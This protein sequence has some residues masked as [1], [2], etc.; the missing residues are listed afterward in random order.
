MGESCWEWLGKGGANGYGMF[1]IR[2]A[3]RQYK[4]LLAH[5]F[6]WELHFGEIP[7][8]LF[9]LHH[10]D[11]RKCVNP[12]H[13][14][15]GTQ[16]DNIADMWAK[17]RGVHGEQRRQSKLKEVQVKEIRE[18]YRAGENISAVARG[19]GVTRQAV[20]AAAIGKN[21]KRLEER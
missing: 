1:G 7:A 5:R 18:R 3:R 17:G 6:S 12:A 21:W 19:Y 13:L 20:H 9:V 11:N 14:F 4:N 8:N 10:C 16:A 2:I 15:L